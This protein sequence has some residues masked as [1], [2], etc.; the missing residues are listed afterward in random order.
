[1][2]FYTQNIYTKFLKF[3]LKTSNELNG[4]KIGDSSDL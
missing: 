1:M 2:G 4:I 3:I